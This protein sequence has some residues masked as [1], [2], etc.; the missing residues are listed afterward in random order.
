MNDID[1]KIRKALNAE[2]QKILDDFG[3][4]LGPLDMVVQSFKGKQWWI[5][6]MLYFWGIVTFGVM[7]FCTMNYFNTNDLKESMSWGIGI[8]LCG[9]MFTIVKITGWQQLQN[10]AI[11]REIKRLELRWMNSMD[12]ENN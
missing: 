11:V 8:L 9:M 6:A 7:I 3:E 1:E 4:D 5:M 12:Q 10:Q 2:D